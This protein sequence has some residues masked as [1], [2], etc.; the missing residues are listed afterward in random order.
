MIRRLIGG[1]LAGLLTVQL[2]SCAFTASVETMLSPPRMTPEQEDIYHA[3]QAGIASS[4]SLK[5]PKSG[6]RLSAFTVEDLDGD[7]ADE[8]IVFYQSGRS[9]ADENPLRLCLL[10]QE[11]GA[12]LAMGEY[13][14]AGAEVER[15]DIEQLGDNPRKNLI[16]RYS[17]VDGANCTA[18]VLN[19]EDGAL[20]RSL[21]LPYSRMNVR[22]LNGDG[23]NELLVLSGTTTSDAA[24]A[25]VYTLDE[26][27]N[28]LQPALAPLP[29]TVTDISGIGY[30][31]MQAESGAGTIPVIYIDGISGATTV[32]TVVLSYQENA[33]SVVYT[34]SPDRFPNTA[35]SAGLPTADL[36]GDGEPEIPVQTVFYGYANA[37]DGS[38]LNLTNWYVCRGGLL[39]REFSS[40]YAVQEG[41]VFLMP[42]RWERK[43]TAVPE[44]EEIV[45]YE[46]DP[47]AQKE[48][49]S[50]VL[51]AS[52]LRLRAVTDA[53][54]ADTLQGDGYLLLQQRSGCYYL[55]L[56]ESGSASL[57]L[58]QSELLFAMKYL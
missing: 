32:Q 34:D 2:P 49:G 6:E 44:G 20:T 43:V 5:Y 45:F 30:G 58:T 47:S 46:I 53:V 22:D 15:V 4:I 38:P 33:L 41:Y 3:L 7:G 31:F 17:M 50:P 23:T 10:A 14:T 19:Y 12:W 51:R 24:S 26:A 9:A 8:A 36:N 39:M 29:E 27:G 42:K 28:Y 57:T 21:R 1:L 35:R 54:E 40:Y 52:L 56:L 48:D 55:A 11:N 37:E 16:I 13:P 18:E 25:T